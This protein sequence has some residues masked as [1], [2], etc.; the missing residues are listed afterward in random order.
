MLSRLVWNSSPQR[1]AW[2]RGNS[3]SGAQFETK[4]GNTVRLCLCKKIQIISQMCWHMTILP[5]TQ[6]A[7]VGGHLRLGGGGCS[8]SWLCHCTPGWAMRKDPVSKKTKKHT[9]VRSKTENIKSSKN[10]QVYLMLMSHISMEC[11]IIIMLKLARR[12]FS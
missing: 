5:A 1:V 8:E 3:I 2:G 12:L 9:P 4:L 10:Y 11:L 7:E 6:G